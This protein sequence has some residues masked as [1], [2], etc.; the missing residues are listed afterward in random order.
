MGGNSTGASLAASISLLARDEG[1]SPPLTG[2]L[3]SVPTVIYPSVIPEKYRD[4]YLARE[5]NA[6]APYYLNRLN[7]VF[8]GMR[9]SYRL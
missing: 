8:Q 1:L 7:E 3:L 5:Q 4:V 9:S 2:V 6:N